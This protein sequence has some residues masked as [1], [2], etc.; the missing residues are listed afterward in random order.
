MRIK[1][2]LQ[3]IVESLGI[4]PIPIT[5]AITGTARREPP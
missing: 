2:I 4:R 5:P 1:S 3:A